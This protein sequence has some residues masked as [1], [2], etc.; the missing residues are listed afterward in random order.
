MN[1]LALDALSLPPGE[2]AFT[3]S[4]RTLSSVSFEQV[5]FYPRTNRILF[6]VKS[7]FL[8]TKSQEN[9]DFDTVL[10]RGTGSTKEQLQMAALALAG[11]LLDMSQVCLVTNPICDGF[12]SDL[13]RTPARLWRPAAPWSSTW[14][15]QR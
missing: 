9:R 11:P 4:L 7:D 5:K 14:R 10:A 15:A 2:S 1:G 6:H 12:K 13:H 8:L 3:A